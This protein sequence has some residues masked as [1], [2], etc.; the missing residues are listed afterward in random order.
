[1]LRGMIGFGLEWGIE[2]LVRVTGKRV[3]NRN[4]S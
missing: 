3:L 2:I 1:M 4:A